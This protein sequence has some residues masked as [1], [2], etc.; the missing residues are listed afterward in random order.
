MR[1]MGQLAHG[2]YTDDCE[3]VHPDI[4]RQYYGT[5]GQPIHRAPHQTDAGHASDKEYSDPDSDTEESGN[6]T[7]GDEEFA[8]DGSEEEWEDID[9]DEENLQ[10]IPQLIAADHSAYF[11]D[12]PIYVPK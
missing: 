5:T 4:I 2:L 12:K 9:Q 6:G 10:D 3:G 7:S 1:L 11:H 8:G